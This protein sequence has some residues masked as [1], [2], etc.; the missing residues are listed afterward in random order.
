[1]P[2]WATKLSMTELDRGLACAARREGKSIRE[3]AEALHRDDRTLAKLFMKRG[4][5][6]ERRRRKA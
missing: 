5:R 1:M 2:R 4:I 6:L 3:I